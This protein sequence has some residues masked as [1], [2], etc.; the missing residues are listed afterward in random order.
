MPDTL[1][2]LNAN[3]LGSTFGSIPQS[4][5]FCQFP[6]APCFY[7]RYTGIGFRLFHP[8]P[9]RQGMSV[10]WLK[11]CPFLAMSRGRILT[12]PIAPVLGPVVA[13]EFAPR[14]NE[15][16]R[17][18]VRLGDCAVRQS[19]F[20]TSKSNFKLRLYHFYACQLGNQSE[21]SFSADDHPLL[22]GCAGRPREPRLRLW[23]FYQTRSS[24]CFSQLRSCSSSRRH[25]IAVVH[26]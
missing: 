18:T 19:A 1:L 3:L 22:I 11:E 24:F 13:V 2:S 4:L 25:Q 17:A 15:K 9:I 16:G 8:Q 10:H 14:L 6:S 12:V 23:N 21:R 7:S 20:N 26:Y 5:S